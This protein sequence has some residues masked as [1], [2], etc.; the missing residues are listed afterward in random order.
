MCVNI[1]CLHVC[2]FRTLSIN[3]STVY[4]LLKRAHRFSFIDTGLI[5]ERHFRKGSFIVGIMKAQMDDTLR[6]QLCNTVCINLSIKWYLQI[7]GTPS[8]LP[9]RYGC[10][11]LSIVFQVSHSSQHHIH[12]CMYEYS[13]Y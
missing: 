3:T 11:D 2:H 13:T 5:V 6:F 10:I 4:F 12:K 1:Y 7:R 9:Q 8:S